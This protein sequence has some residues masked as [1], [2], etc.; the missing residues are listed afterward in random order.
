MIL[1]NLARE[2]QFFLWSVVGPFLALATI[3]LMLFHSTPLTPFFALTMVIGVP[4]CWSLKRWGIVLASVVLTFLI[5]LNAH[6]VA[7]DLIWHIGIASS[8]ILTLFITQQSSDE[9]TSLVEEFSGNS[10]ENQKNIEQYKL[11]VENLKF[12]HQNDQLVLQKKLEALIQEL[13]HSEEKSFQYHETIVK[14]KNDVE[15]ARNE[16]DRAKSEAEVIRGEL[17]AQV[18]KEEHV[19]QELLEKR[20]EVYQLRDQLQEAQEELKNPSVETQIIQDDVELQNLRDLINKKEQDLFNIQFRLDS[21]LEDIQ[22][23]ENELF[24]F[25]NGEMLQKKLQTEMSDQIEMLKREKDLL[26]TTIQKLHHETEQLFSHKLEKERLEESLNLTL[27]EL[28]KVRAEVIQE[29]LREIINTPRKEITDPHLA[30]EYSI[31][32]RAEGMYLQLK[33]QFNEKA[34]ILDDT[35]RQLFHTQENLLQLQRCLNEREH[36]SINPQVRSLTKHILKM[37][38]HFERQEKSYHAE[39]DTLHDIVAKLIN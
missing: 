27:K 30:Q 12:K 37:Q 10:V 26:E 36:F 16:A 29:P 25:Q 19:L 13:K 15:I 20:K 8:I 7:Q 31:R 17:E 32:R 3:L 23:Q 35:R 2:R 18:I 21:A 9:S 34:T 22:E 39:I 5:F 24:K 28:E 38:N 6:S 11:D 1:M 33:E 4:V 14:A